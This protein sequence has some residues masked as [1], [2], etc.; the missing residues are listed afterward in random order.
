MN[1]LFIEAEECFYMPVHT[2]IPKRWAYLAE[3]ASFINCNG[4][5][6]KVMD[7][8]DPSVSH[9]EVLSE[10]QSLKYDVV[11]FLVRIETVETL[12]KLALLVKT[13]DP[14]CR[15]LAY[16]DAP[17]MF[18]EYIKRTMPSLDALVTS[19]DWEV[20]ILNYIK[21]V[22]GGEMCGEI[23]PGVSV[24]D[25]ETWRAGA[26][27]CNSGFTDWAFPSLDKPVVNKDLYLSLTGGELTISVSR[28]CVYNCE[29]CLAVKTFL[30]NDRRKAPAEVV[31][32]MI[33]NMSK[34]NGYKLFSPT[35]TYDSEWVYNFCN[36]LISKGNTISWV[37]TSRPDCLQ[38]QEMLELMALAGCK[39][40]AVGIETLDELSIEELGKYGSVDDYKGLVSSMLDKSRRC[41]IEIKPLL[42]L[43]IEGQSSSNIDETIRFLRE[44]GATSIRVAAY[45]PRQLLSQKDSKG[46]LTLSDIIEMDKMS[47]INYL[48]REMSI[49]DFYSLTF[50]R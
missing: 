44:K 37:T 17:C 18:P 3:I 26:K 16:G 9:A 25:G 45:S 39:K 4:Y 2:K 49:R 12:P 38:D 46:E 19:G 41:G 14:S 50:G 43:G 11:C 35:F 10:V 6:V 34:V 8:L 48:P 15:L 32:Y 33:A 22:E 31:D 36:L 30:S 40:I 29:F 42:M 47:Y 23:I 21:Y 28:G 7:C 27:L 1:I 20:S 24:Y 5:N 13:L